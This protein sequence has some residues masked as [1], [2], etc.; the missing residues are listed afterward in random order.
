MSCKNATS[1]FVNEENFLYMMCVVDVRAF[2]KEDIHFMERVHSLF[3]ESKEKY[4]ALLERL[5]DSSENNDWGDQLLRDSVNL[6]SSEDWDIL[7]KTKWYVFLSLASMT[8]SLLNHTSWQKIGKRQVKGVLDILSKESSRQCFTKYQELLDA[9]Y[10]YNIQIDEGLANAISHHLSDFVC[11]ILSKA[12]STGIFIDSLMRECT[13]KQDEVIMWMKNEFNISQDVTTRFIICDLDPKSN[14]VKDSAS[15]LWRK[16][17]YKSSMSLDYYIF[18]FVLSFNWFKDADAIEYMKYAFM[19]IYKSVI[20]SQ[21]T[22]RQWKKLENLMEPLKIWQ[23]WDKGK[24]MR[25][26]LAKRLKVAGMPK[27]YVSEFTPD[28]ELNH[29]ILK[30][31]KKY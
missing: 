5:I 24:K 29:E 30:Y 3:E 11:T 1:Y 4:V 19:P 9:I 13:G 12:N 2:Y 17:I 20:T 26:T 22:L 10:T 8:P 28:D 18:I 14:I 7:I 15:A 16:V 6:L 31:W 23:D 25:K 21:I 27:S